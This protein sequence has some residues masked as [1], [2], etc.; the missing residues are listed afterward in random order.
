MKL[1]LRMIPRTRTREGTWEYHG[2]YIDQDE[3]KRYL[4][5]LTHYIYDA[6]SCLVNDFMCIE[7][8]ANMTSM[9]P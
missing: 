1:T 7:C 5:V 9:S 6:A 4:K 8:A 3:R 2:I